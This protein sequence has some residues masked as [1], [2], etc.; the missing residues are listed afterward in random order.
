MSVEE[1]RRRMRLRACWSAVLG[2]LLGAV[3]AVVL[4]SGQARLLVTVLSAA[5]GAALGYLLARGLSRG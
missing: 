3:G 2:M 4:V 5:A 1:F